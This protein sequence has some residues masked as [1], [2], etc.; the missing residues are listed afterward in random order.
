MTEDL[1]VLYDADCGICTHTARVLARLDS[2]RRLRLI[3]IQG[4]ALAKM[5]PIDELMGALHAVDAQDQW[6]AGAVASVE[7]ARRI[8]LLWPVTIFARLPLAMR[9]LDVM[10]EAVANHRQQLSRLLGLNVCKVPARAPL[11]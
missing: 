6:S 11:P 3:P 1:T 5:P 2:R 8:R 7:I 9:V 4:A 10:Y